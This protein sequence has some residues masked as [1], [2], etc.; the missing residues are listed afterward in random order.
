MNTGSHRSAIP[1]FSAGISSPPGLPVL[2]NSFSP[3]RGSCS[4]SV[5]R[6][7]GTYTVFPL[8]SLICKEKG[9]NGK[10]MQER[11]TTDNLTVQQRHL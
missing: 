11:G 1:A 3:Y 7:A 4:I 8:S 9:K 2:G 10:E 5:V 6:T